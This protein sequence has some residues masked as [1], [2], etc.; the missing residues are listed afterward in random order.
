MEIFTLLETLEDLLEN[1]RSL[2]FTDKGI[3]DK[4][5]MLDLIKEIRIKQGFTQ[6]ALSFALNKTRNFINVREAGPKKYNVEHLNQ[7][8]KIL[9]C[10]A[11][12]F[13]PEKP[14]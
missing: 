8:A 11:R 4:E 6:E 14:I 7:I 3:V 12:D 5:E 1:S 2:P 13:L 10:S 9:K